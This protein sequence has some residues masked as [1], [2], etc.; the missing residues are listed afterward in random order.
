MKKIITVLT[1]SA[2]FLALCF[3]VQAQQTGEV[4]RIG[5]LDN[6]TAS[7]SAI[8]VNAFRQE[9]SKLGWIEGKNIT[10]GYRFSDGKPERLPELVAELLRLKVDVIVTRGGPPNL[11]A[12]NATTTIPIVMAVSA[13]P[14]GEGLVTSLARPGGNVTG[15]SGLLPELN[16]KRLEILKDA[17]P[18]LTRVGL[19]HGPGDYIGGALQLKELRAAAL[20]LKL[21]LEEIKTEPNA[22]GIES[23]FQTA[24]Q[25]QVDAIMTLTDTRFFAERKRLVELA[26]KYRLPAIYFQREFVD[27]GGLM[28]YGADYVDLFRRAAMYV[29][30]I[31]KGAKPADLP[32]Q[33]AT[34]FEFVINLKAAKQIGLTLSPE[35][36]SRANTVI[37]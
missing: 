1:L 20:A 29:D 24:K 5:F 23:A 34:K 8:L 13:D 11:A 9:L 32:V 28:Y 33:Q 15:N 6:S 17:V 21:K 36:L 19:L 14:V 31:L 3:P 16:T 7:G 10:I 2:M 12:K 27:E 18:K 26:A 25:R 37:K 4:F 35:F 30:K 22:K